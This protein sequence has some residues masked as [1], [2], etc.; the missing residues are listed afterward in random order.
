MRP[1]GT[2]NGKQPSGGVKLCQDICGTRSGVP[3]ES[4]TGN[5]RTVVGTQPSPAPGPSSLDWQKSCA[6]R[7]IP[8]IGHCEK[9]SSFKRARHC[10]VS[11]LRAAFEKWPTPGMMIGFSPSMSLGIA[12]IL[13]R[14]PIL[15]SIFITDP[16]FPV[17]RSTTST[18]FAI[19]EIDS[20]IEGRV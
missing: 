5:R 6:P 12:Q 20:V 7:Q 14:V 4:V 16:T 19:V 17:S 18:L 1:D 10:P 13:G 9:C 8:K 15:V 11:K 2:E 3:V